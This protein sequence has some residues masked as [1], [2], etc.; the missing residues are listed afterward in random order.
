MRTKILRWGNSLGLRIP[1]LLAEQVGV[2]AGSTMDVS[3]ED[4]TLVARPVGPPAYQLQ[5]LLDAI[6][7]ENVHEPV[8][9]GA[10]VGRE[11]W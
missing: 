4:G 5:E 10:P 1:K 7:P 9:W 3:V 11:V 2:E 6:T 8:E